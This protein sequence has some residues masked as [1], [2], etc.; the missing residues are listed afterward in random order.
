[1]LFSMRIERWA[2]WCRGGRALGW[3]LAGL[4]LHL[5]GDWLVGGG[6]W[7]TMQPD[8]MAISDA[9]GWHPETSGGLRVY[10]MLVQLYTVF[11]VPLAA[12]WLGVL[13]P[14]LWSRALRATRPVFAL[15]LVASSIWTLTLAGYVLDYAHLWV[16]TEPQPPDWV[17]RA[18]FSVGQLMSGGMTLSAWLIFLG[19]C[20]VLIRGLHTWVT[21]GPGRVQA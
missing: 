2:D 12:L 10:R 8:G 15:T 7:G 3:G 18:Q 21:T 11:Y 5:A 1:M 16:E 6:C 4:G 9:A 14:A 20:A 17:W 13:V 19:F